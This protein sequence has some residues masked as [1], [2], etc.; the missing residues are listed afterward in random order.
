MRKIY[1]I[2][3]GK[4]DIPEG[5]RMCLGSTDLPL[6]SLGRLQAALIGAA[7]ESY[8]LDAVYC[9]RLLRSRQTAE[10]IGGPISI[11]PGLEEMYAGEW[12]GLTFDEIKKRWPELYDLR[13]RDLS[14][15]PP[16]AETRESGQSR[17]MAAVLRALSESAGDIAVVAHASVMQTLLCTA[18]GLPLDGARSI[19]LP[20]GSVSL[21]S[22]EAGVFSVLELGSLPHPFPDAALCTRLL[23]AADL[24]PDIPA[25]CA[26]VAAGAANISR[27]LVH[28]G[29]ALDEDIIFAAAMLHDIARTEKNHS[30]KGADMLLALGYPRIADVIRQHHDLGDVSRIDEAAVVFIADKLVRGTKR[31]TI[32]ERFEKSLEKCMT[33]EAEKAHDKRYEAA[34]SV[35]GKINSICGKEIVR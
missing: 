32:R 15:S 18:I 13:G 8:G 16:G 30:A 34:V 9:S 21:L 22:Y 35:A 2:R 7:L 31:V 27:A 14:V 24:P 19:E 20:Y 3:H 33:A 1:L 17:F 6:G 28:A 29:L 5:V 4:P 12:D 26:E 11:L 25:H 23:D 10:L